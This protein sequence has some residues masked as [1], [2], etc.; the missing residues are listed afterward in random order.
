MTAMLASA[1]ALSL[2]ASLGSTLAHAEP[3]ADTRTAV[4][5]R[6]LMSHALLQGLGAHDPSIPS[7]QRFP[8]PACDTTQST[9]TAGERV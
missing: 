2:A 9:T 4:L 5:G 6:D 8:D 1:S 7:P 3:T